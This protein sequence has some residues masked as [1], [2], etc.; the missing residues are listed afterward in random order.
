MFHSRKL[1]TRINIIH[2]RALRIVYRDAITPHFEQEDD[3]CT[4]HYPNLQLLATGVYKTKNDLSPKFMHDEF[5][6]RDLNHRNLRNQT[7][8]QLDL[9]PRFHS[10]KFS[11]ERKNFQYAHVL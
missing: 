7:H 1:N 11:A 9:K 10:R 2:E 6:Q 3:P 5:L 8:F 4:I